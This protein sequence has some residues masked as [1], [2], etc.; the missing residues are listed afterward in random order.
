M[1]DTPSGSSGGD[2][3]LTN[4]P[5]SDVVQGSSAAHAPA[6]Q[7][8]CFACHHTGHFQ[9][10][11]KPPFLFNFP[12]GGLSHCALQQSFPPPPVLKQFG[13]R[14]SGCGFFWHGG[15]GQH[16]CVHSLSKNTAI[17]SVLEGDVLLLMLTGELRKW[18]MEDWD[19]KIEQLSAS[20]FD[21][22]V[23]SVEIL[24]IAA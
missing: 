3:L 6:S 15:Q 19:W 7:V 9:A 20:E 21:V 12:Y 14:I 5:A 16:G 2:G 10:G 18:G 17:M 24:R 13:L 22:V 8:T 11:C 23:P 1:W 4:P